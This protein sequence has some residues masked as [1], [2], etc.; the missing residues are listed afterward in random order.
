MM[1]D[2]LGTSVTLKKNHTQPGGQEKDKPSPCTNKRVKAIR[3]FGCVLPLSLQKSK[4]YTE[5]LRRAHATSSRTNNE[6]RIEAL[7]VIGIGR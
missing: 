1:Q 3:D 4:E 5:A 6:A 2:C 7:K